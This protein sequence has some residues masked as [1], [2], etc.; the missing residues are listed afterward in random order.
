M[1]IL[2]QK[3]VQFMSLANVFIQQITGD[4]PA[5]LKLSLIEEL[6]SWKEPNAP[7][8]NMGV[9]LSGSTKDEYLKDLENLVREQ[10]SSE[11]ITVEELFWLYYTALTLE[12][13]LPISTTQ[14]KT[15]TDFLKRYLS[16]TG[17]DIE[18]YISTI[19]LM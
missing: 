14:E 6:S 3:E 16:N 8:C 9:L 11:K 4:K 13:E 19:K 17:E 7:L 18:A 15:A 1:S 5:K 12:F 2:L 10:A